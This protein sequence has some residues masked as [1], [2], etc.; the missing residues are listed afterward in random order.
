LKEFAAIDKPFPVLTSLEL[1]SSQQQDVT[2]LPD[3]FLGGSAP[4]LRSLVLDGIPCPSIGKLLSSTTNP[5]RLSLWRIPHSGYISPETIVP[6]LS[7]LSRLE[8]IALGFQ[9]PRSLAHRANRHPPSPTRAVFPNLT[10]LCFRGNIEYLE[11]IL[12]Q[13][14][15][16]MLN[17]IEFCFFNQ[18]VF[19]TPQLG[20]FIRRT[21]TFMKIYAARVEFFSLAVVVTFW[22]Q[23]EMVHNL[24]DREALQLEIPCQPLD[25]QLSAVAQ[26]LDSFLSSLPTLESL[27]IEV[28]RED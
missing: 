14:E 28:S 8:S 7:M 9:H 26:V 17:Q 23:E 12:F 4:R 5:V 15:T 19:D 20:Y 27:E 25:W 18:L 11:D 1:F 16:P 10:L 3:S 6:L 24:N 13:I 21:E 22:E 2:V